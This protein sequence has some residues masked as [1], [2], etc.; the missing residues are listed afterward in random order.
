MQLL[1]STYYYLF[2]K[3]FFNIFRFKINFGVVSLYYGFWHC[4]LYLWGMSERP[5]NPNRVYRI[6]KVLHNMWYTFLGVV[7]ITIWEA[8]FMYCW[9][10]K[11]LPFMTD[12]EA[13]S[14]TWNLSM[15]ILSAFW[16]PTVRDVHFYF[17]HR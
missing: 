10:T 16:V 9:A 4:A 6:E 2:N 15:V 8:I 7:Q 17:A 3:S 11:R 1:P 5:F 13:T 12:E 14:T